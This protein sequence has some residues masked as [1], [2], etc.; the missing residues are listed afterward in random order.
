MRDRRESHTGCGSSPK[1]KCFWEPENTYVALKGDKARLQCLQPGIPGFCSGRAGG[2][3]LGPERPLGRH[4]TR[5]L[6]P[7][8]GIGETCRKPAGRWASP[9]LAPH[10]RPI[11]WLPTSFF[12]QM[13]CYKLAYSPGREHQQEPRE[14]ASRAPP[15]FV[16]NLKVSDTSFCLCGQ[17]PQALETVPQNHLAV[18][19]TAESQLGSR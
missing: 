4:P 10:N 12:V 14:Q 7:V 3:V 18:T 1:L 13:F 17:H 19:C 2:G 16:L 6:W 5:P 15:P 9:P 8:A 11:N